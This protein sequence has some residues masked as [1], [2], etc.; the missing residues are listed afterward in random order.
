MGALFSCCQEWNSYISKA[1]TMQLKP[2]IDADKN[3]D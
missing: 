1:G 2:Q 3:C